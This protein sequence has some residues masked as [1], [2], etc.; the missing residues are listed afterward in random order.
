M[1][2][3]VV[4]NAVAPGI[5]P[6]IGVEQLFQ[7]RCRIRGAAESN[8]A[9]VEQEGL[10]RIVG[11]APVVLERDRVRLAPANRPARG[12]DRRLAGASHP[13]QRLFQV[14][15]HVHGRTR[16]PPGDNGPRG[17]TFRNGR[18]AHAAFLRR[19]DGGAR[20][21]EA[22]RGCAPRFFS[23]TLRRK[24]SIRSTTLLGFSSLAAASIFLPEAFR[25]TSL[26]RA[27]SYRSVNFFGS[28]CAVLVSRICSA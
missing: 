21:R 16:K 18:L 4:I 11:N 27:V 12:R 7:E 25:F 20:L 8:R 15:Q 14:L 24:A 2:V 26:R 9:T 3:N 28:K 13:F 5:A 22:V 17:N 10:A 6:V 19:R 23:P 1:V